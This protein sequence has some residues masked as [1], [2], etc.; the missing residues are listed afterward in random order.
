MLYQNLSFNINKNNNKNIRT[1]CEMLKVNNTKMRSTDNIHKENKVYVF[2]KEKQMLITQN[3]KY[4]KGE[5][6]R[7]S[8][9]NT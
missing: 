2:K 4:E 9:R 6:L 1:R 3:M 5:T 8:F 7:G